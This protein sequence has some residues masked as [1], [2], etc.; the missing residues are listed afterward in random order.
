MKF[1]LSVNF[2]VKPWPYLSPT[3]KDAEEIFIYIPQGVTDLK[4]ACKSEYLSNVFDTF[5]CTP[6]AWNYN[7]STPVT[8]IQCQ[9][10]HN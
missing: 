3:H 5:E 6:E 10:N 1:I 8:P 7:I 4:N 9:L 2:E